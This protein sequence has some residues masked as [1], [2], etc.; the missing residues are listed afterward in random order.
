MNYKPFELSDYFSK[1]YYTPIALPMTGFAPLQLLLQDTATQSLKK[2]V[3][4][5]CMNK[6]LYIVRGDDEMEMEYL[7]L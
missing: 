7:K 2:G 3:F 1:F 4:S 5:I 6:A